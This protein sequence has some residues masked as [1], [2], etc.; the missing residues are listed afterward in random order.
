MEEIGKILGSIIFEHEKDYFNENN[1]I[2]INLIIK[3]KLINFFCNP[4]IEDKMI[5]VIN[6]HEK[7]SR[8]DCKN[9]L[10]LLGLYNLFSTILT[11]KNYTYFD[12]YLKIQDYEKIIIQEKL[13][14]YRGNIL[15]L[16][17]NDEN[18][19][20]NLISTPKKNLSKFFRNFTFKF[21]KNEIYE[22]IETNKYYQYKNIQK[23]NQEYL[24]NIIIN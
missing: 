13:C 7:N 4:D 24:N 19:F 8:L 18:F 3:Q 2:S 20:Y 5:K 1:N 12:Y 23:Y 9:N 22:I 11:I 14:L 17:Q 10:V 6:S 21:Q 16:Y 15:S